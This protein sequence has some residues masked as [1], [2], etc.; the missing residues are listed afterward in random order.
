MIDNIGYL[1][2]ILLGALEIENQNL[3]VNSLITF[4][5]LLNNFMNPIKEIIDS[6]LEYEE[7]LNSLNRILE[8]NYD[9]K[10]NGKIKTISNYDIKIKNLTFSYNEKK[11]LDNISINIKEFN[12]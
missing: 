11:I 6:N 7:S 4:S 8:L 3:D 5:F 2:I 10:D 1:V 9:V 12:Y